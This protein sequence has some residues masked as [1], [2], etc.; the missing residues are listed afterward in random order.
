MCPHGNSSD[1]IWPS[2]TPG[3]W[4]T[5]GLRW[6]TS[7][8]GSR[9]AADQSQT[10]VGGFCT[11]T[12]AAT[13]RQKDG[14]TQADSEGGTEVWRE[15][16]GQEDRRT[17]GREDGSQRNWNFVVSSA[18]DCFHGKIHLRR[19]YANV[20]EQ[21]RGNAPVLFLSFHQGQKNALT[22]KSVHV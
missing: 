7:L 3:G 22:S 12:G 10:T 15:A 20:L 21:E 18:A 6:N 14:R 4:D 19:S 16:G 11:Q 8:G 13:G 17:G 2:A 5:E 1:C 9:E